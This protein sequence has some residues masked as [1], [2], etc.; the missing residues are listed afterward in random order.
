MCASL[1][2]RPPALAADPLGPG[3]TYPPI[4]RTVEVSDTAPASV[5]NMATG[6]G[7]GGPPNGYNSVTLVTAIGR[8]PDLTVAVKTH[9]GN[10]TRGAKRSSPTA[11]P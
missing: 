11:S 9:T 4:T 7:G 1:E 6:P 10:F 3:A 5:T 2:A 8:G